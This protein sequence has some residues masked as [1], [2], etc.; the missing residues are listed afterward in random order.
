MADILKRIEAYKRDEIAAAKSAVPLSELT[1]RIRDGVI[2]R[3]ASPRR[4]VG[5]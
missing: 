3:A 2:L 1:S 4:C 5:A